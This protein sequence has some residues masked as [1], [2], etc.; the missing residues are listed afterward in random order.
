MRYT[1]TKQVEPAARVAGMVE[2][3]GYGGLSRCRTD[4]QAWRPR[5][6][7][8]AASRTGTASPA[9]ACTE[10][11]EVQERLMCIA[12]LYPRVKRDLPRQGCAVGMPEGAAILQVKPVQ[13]LDQLR[14]SMLRTDIASVVNHVGRNKTPDIRNNRQSR[15]RPWNPCGW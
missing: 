2:P 6:R 5:E 4:L 1:E 10:S 11:R 9:R 3:L 13:S 8:G 7:V 12:A 15:C 14:A